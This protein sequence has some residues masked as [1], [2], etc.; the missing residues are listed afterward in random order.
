MRQVAAAFLVVFLASCATSPIDVIQSAETIEQRAGALY[1]TWVIAQ[2]AGARIVVLPETPDSVVFAIAS[3]GKRVK[4]IVDAMQDSYIAYTVQKDLVQATIN[5]GETVDT[6]AL[7]QLQSLL[8]TLTQQ[9]ERAEPEVDSFD[10]L[11]NST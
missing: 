1:G 7:Q 8:L 3:S 4:P 2:E 5:A 11:V 10:F 9:V 6:S